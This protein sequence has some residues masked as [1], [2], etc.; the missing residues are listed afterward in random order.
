[1]SA[2]DELI[3]EAESKWICER[4]GAVATSQY[5]SN[6]NLPFPPRRE[7]ERDA[8]AE[9]A[10][11]RAENERVEK[12]YQLAVAGCVKACNERDMHKR[13]WENTMAH[14]DRLGDALA[15]SQ[16]ELEAARKVIVDMV[17]EANL[18]DAFEDDN[19]FAALERAKDFLDS[20]EKDLP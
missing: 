17:H 6:C 3:A 18:Q 7:L 14:R 10:Q 20:S 2:L 1:M 19:G 11:L 8:S 13:N 5:C 4:C 15:A 12:A 16:K 9:L